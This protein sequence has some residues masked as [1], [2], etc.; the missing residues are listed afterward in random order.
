[1]LTFK[2]ATARPIAVR[3]GLAVAALTALGYGLASLFMDKPGL[4]E[5]GGPGAKPWQR[6]FGQGR[7]KK[8]VSRAKRPGSPC[9][10]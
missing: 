8:G 4:A 1:M 7:C 10:W 6:L 9:G 5:Q 2:S 3:I